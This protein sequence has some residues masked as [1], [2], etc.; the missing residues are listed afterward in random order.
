MLVSKPPKI[1][2]EKTIFIGED[3]GGTKA[4]MPGTMAGHAGHCRPKPAGR[5][6]EPGSTSSHTGHN[7]H[8]PAGHNLCR[9][10]QQDEQVGSR[11]VRSEGKQGIYF[12]STHLSSSVAGTENGEDDGDENDTS[13]SGGWSKGGLSQPEELHRCSGYN[14][15]EVY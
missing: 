7:G 15:I 3:T 9:R 6:P 10:R 1:D 13:D 2:T 11:M 4:S 12:I 8:K 14:T 5:A